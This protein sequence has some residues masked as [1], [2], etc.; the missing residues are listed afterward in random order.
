MG[1]VLVGLQVTALGSIFGPSL[2][3]NVFVNGLRTR[4]YVFMRLLLVLVI[5]C[6][7]VGPSSAI[8][9]LPSADW[10]PVDMK[11]PSEG[12]Q[13]FVNA[14][15]SML[16]PTQITVE[17]SIPG[18]CNGTNNTSLEH[19]PA[20]GLFAI[21]D[22][23]LRQKL[24]GERNV[25]NITL[26]TGTKYPRHIESLC[27]FT[28]MGPDDRDFAVSVGTTTSTFAESFLKRVD[29][30]ASPYAFLAKDYQLELFLRGSQKMCVPYVSTFCIQAYGAT[31]TECPIFDSTL[32]F[33]NR[34]PER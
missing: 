6:A 8:L 11:S 19:C 33:P 10:W 34:T 5:L 22:S 31:E 15:E 21:R 26:G 32:L 17:N 13:F 9:M 28:P 1:S 16:W 20:G 25:L 7:I 29:Y 18:D 12:P 27:G 2:W 24:N 3:K 30:L 23:I 14:T 4:R